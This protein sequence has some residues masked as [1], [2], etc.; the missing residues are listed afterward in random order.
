MNEIKFV[1]FLTDLLYNDESGI[2]RTVGT[3]EDFM[4]MTHNNGL[5]V[6]LGDGSEFQLTVVQTKEAKE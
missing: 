2:V 3:Y 4:V 6:K 5:V 1:E